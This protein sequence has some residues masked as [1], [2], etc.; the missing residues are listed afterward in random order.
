MSHPR[1][2]SQFRNFLRRRELNRFAK[3]NRMEIQLMKTLSRILVAVL[4]LVTLSLGNALAQGDSDKQKD[5]ERP[6]AE[7]AKPGAPRP[8]A[9]KPGAPKPDVSKSEAPKK[10]DKA[11][12][13]QLKPASPP[14]KAAEAP[15]KPS[16]PPPG[17]RP[18]GRPFP[19]EASLKFREEMRS[20]MEEVQKL[21]KAGKNEEAEKKMAEMRKKFEA[22]REKAG[23]SER[24][25]GGPPMW[26]QRGPGQ[27]KG[28][29]P[30]WAQRGP[31]PKMDSKAAPP[32]P[33]G[34]KP[35]IKPSHDGDK[36]ADAKPEDRKGPPQHHREGGHADH[37]EKDH[38][39][40]HPRK[41]HGDRAKWAQ[42]HRPRGPFAQ[43]RAPFPGQFR[44]GPPVMQHRMAMRNRMA[45]A[46]GGNRGYGFSPRPG[47]FA[48]R[49]QP[50]MWGG[51]RGYGFAPRP[52][53]FAPRSQPGMW[54]GP[55]FQAP[56]APFA[57][58]P[59]GPQA[60]PPAHPGM[61]MMQPQRHD[62]AKTGKAGKADKKA[63]KGK[64]RGE[65]RGKK[66]CEK[67]Q[68]N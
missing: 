27:G 61:R 33:D 28:G 68:E 62:S 51:N 56:P 53:G 47:S 37:G 17:P 18:E 13:P 35:P 39:D 64:K 12:S 49:S 58:S 25:R 16:G 11:P 44:G 15:K 63:R 8:D 14:E 36:R 20:H 34:P 31:G 9:P 41:P 57:R 38:A 30:A 65:G 32:K 59:W 54:G 1:G 55:R 26:G 46:W 23:E 21:R 3:F 52:G 19:N 40:K 42:N 22:M 50:G 60:R 29:P 66:E 5:P 48:P 43:P 45:R 67:C 24:G 2:F 6:A 4:A 7:D 10:S